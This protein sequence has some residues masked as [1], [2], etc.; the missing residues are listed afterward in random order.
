MKRLLPASKGFTLIELMVVVTI[1]AFLSVIGIVAFTN[2][3]KQAR[4]SR[5]RADIE[6][7][8]TALE[9]NRISTGYQAW[10]TPAI[11]ANNAVPKDPIKDATYDYALAPTSAAG[12]DKFTVCAKLELGNGNADSA[13]ASATSGTHYCRKNQQ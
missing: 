9:S 12:G 7:I 13:G 5:R 10:D 8:A 4:D 6:V 1:I 2:A 3:Q 11:Y